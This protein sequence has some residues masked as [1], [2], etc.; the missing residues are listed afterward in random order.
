MVARRSLWMRIRSVAASASTIATTTTTVMVTAR[1]HD[2][3]P[4]SLVVLRLVERR[5]AARDPAVYDFEH[6]VAVLEHVAIVS[7]HNDGHI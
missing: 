1:G 7:N 3:M 6:A 2:L 4:P 5:G